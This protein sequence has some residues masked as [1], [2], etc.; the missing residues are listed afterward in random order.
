[1]ITFKDEFFNVYDTLNCGQVFRFDKLDG[2]EFL[3]KSKDK[4]AILKTR[5]GNVTIDSSDDEYF[6]NYFDLSK[7]YAKIINDVS[8]CGVEKVRISAQKYK[9]IRILKQDAEEA[10]FSFIV[11]QNNNIPKIKSTIEKLCIALG[12][13]RNFCGYDYYT[14]PTAKVFACCDDEVLKKA[15]LGY[16]AEYIK[17]SAEKILGG[18]IDFAYLNTLDTESLK[19]ELLKIKGVGDKVA[20]C[21][22]LFGFSRSDSFPVDTWIEKIYREDFA[23]TLSDRKKINRFFLDTFKENSGYVQQ[24]LFYAKRENFI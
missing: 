5:D 3:V 20:N 14:F 16:R 11:S 17:K 15:G 10:F 13:K 24:Y 1:M 6:K 22:T 19:K 21:V 2:G 9:G 18:E 23:G 12:E 4:T 7:D 8:A